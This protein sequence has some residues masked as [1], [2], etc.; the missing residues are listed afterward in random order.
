MRKTE[1]AGIEVITVYRRS[2][3][4]IDPTQKANS[5]FREYVLAFHITPGLFPAA[6]LFLLHGENLLSK[7]ST[8]NDGKALLRNGNKHRRMRISGDAL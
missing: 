1:I 2:A 5:F 3:I 6:C 8:F 7:F 4:I